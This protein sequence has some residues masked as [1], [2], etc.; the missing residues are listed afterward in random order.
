PCSAIL[1]LGSRRTMRRATAASLTNLLVGLSSSCAGVGG[2]GR[3][4]PEPPVSRRAAVTGGQQL[5]K[6][7]QVLPRNHR[8]RERRHGALA[9]ALPEIGSKR[10]IRKKPRDRLRP[11]VNIAFSYH[12]AGIADDMRNLAAVGSNDRD[13]A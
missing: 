8:P 13:A 10:G 3:R 5:L 2:A 4:V 11:R 1:P 7:V 12:E 9:A 6:K